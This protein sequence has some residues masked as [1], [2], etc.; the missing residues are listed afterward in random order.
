MNNDVREQLREYSDAKVATGYSAL[1]D[2]NSPGHLDAKIMRTAKAAAANQTG[3]FR[4]TAWLRP[5]A[6][7]ATAGL[8]IAL[9]LEINES[10]ILEGPVAIQSTVPASENSGT[11]MQ[12]S[13]TDRDDAERF[14]NA[15]GQA[16]EQVREV[17]AS[18]D[19]TLKEMPKAESRDHLQEAGR[20]ESTAAD[21]AITQ[22]PDAGLV[23]GSATDS[24]A[25]TSEQRQNP[26]DWMTCIDELERAGMTATAA[27]ELTELR[28]SFPH[29]LVQ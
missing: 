16:L 5:L 19:A 28:Q 17:G 21:G 1:P 25:C 14:R 9:L 4:I 12:N 8:S 11:S 24:P 2:E 26:G 10:Q 7:A 27:Q 29:F 13:T 15:A 23:Q 3:L 22:D 6:F 18:E 20:Q